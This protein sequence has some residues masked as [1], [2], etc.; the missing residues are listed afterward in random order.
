MN[1]RLAFPLYRHGAIACG[2]GARELDFRL[3]VERVYEGN[4]PDCN[5]AGPDG[6]NGVRA[7]GAGDGGGVGG[8]EEE[9]E[10]DERRGHDLGCGSE[11]KLFYVF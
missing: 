9:R 3:Q 2:K 6:G 1:T 4:L 10:E 8:G 7:A 5:L 11:R